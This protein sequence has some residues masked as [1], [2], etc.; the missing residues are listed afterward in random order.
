MN[1]QRYWDAIVETVDIKSGKFDTKV[2][3]Y[4]ISQQCFETQVEIPKQNS[5][6]FEKNVI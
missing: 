2:I 4:F 1:N 6:T 5:Q 3:K